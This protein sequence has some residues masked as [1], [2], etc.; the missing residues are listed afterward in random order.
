MTDSAITTPMGE[1]LL[2]AA[3]EGIRRRWAAATGPWS[4]GAVGVMDTQGVFDERGAGVALV[5]TEP[6]ATA[7]ANAPEDVRF[8]LALIEELRG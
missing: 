6:D 7:I 4:V 2:D 5:Y 3:L 8:L 1:E